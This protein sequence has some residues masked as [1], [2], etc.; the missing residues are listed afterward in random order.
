[1]EFSGLSERVHQARG[2]IA[3]RQKAGG[4]AHPVTLIA[5]T[6]GHGPE[7]V[8]AA[9]EAGLRDIGENKVQE[10]TAKQNATSEVAARW[11]LI[12]SLQKNK[13]RH[14][15]GRFSL[16]HSVDREDLGA[17]LARRSAPGSIQP[18]LVQVNCSNEPQKGGVDPE[19]LPALLDQL[20]V[21]LSLEVRGFMTMAALSAD[22]GEQR[23][24]FALLRQL[25][26][27]AVAAG[28]PGHELSMGMSSDYLIAVEE[29]ATMVRLGT[30]LFGER[31][32]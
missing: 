4:W 19:R 15:T 31:S 8:Q 32:R 18:I 14:A 3:E 23:R 2:S 16:I 20:S 10:A 21:M 26:D 11:H 12:G 9:V 24:T 27:T 28:H 6:K 30:L 1:M 5:V 29:G 25:R 22:E 7:A 17:E 13:A